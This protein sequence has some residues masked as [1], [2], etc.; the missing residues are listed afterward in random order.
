MKELARKDN[1]MTKHKLVYLDPYQSLMYSTL[2]ALWEL[3][4]AFFDC[5]GTDDDD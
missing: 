5:G 2:D 1:V 4:L 3:S